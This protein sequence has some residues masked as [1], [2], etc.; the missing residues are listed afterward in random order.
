MSKVLFAA[1][2]MLTLL[3]VAMPSE[4]RADTT[5]LPDMIIY[6]RTPRPAA[7]VEV[8]RARMQLP[9]STPTLSAVTR[10][11]SATKKAPF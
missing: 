1:T 6:G 10:I 7:A 3:L 2:T 11:E 8:S 5:T 9:P 4:C